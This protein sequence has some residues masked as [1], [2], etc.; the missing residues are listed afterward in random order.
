M[1]PHT[2]QLID[3]LRTYPDWQN[4]SDVLRQQLVQ[5]GWDPAVVDEAFRGAQASSPASDFAPVAA[6]QQPVKIR[7]PN[8]PIAAQVFF[9]FSC[10]GLLLGLIAVAI[11][12]TSFSTQT[13]ALLGISHAGYL[14]GIFIELVYYVGVF[15]LVLQMRSLKKWALVAVTALVIVSLLNALQAWLQVASFLGGILGT[16]TRLEV[17]IYGGAAILLAILW[18]KNRRNFHD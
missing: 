2:Q 13:A 15:W 7:R 5:A 14:A 16:N 4:Q 6:T 18:T 11:K 1:N 9:A 10:I 12:F 8:P 17:L 3:Y